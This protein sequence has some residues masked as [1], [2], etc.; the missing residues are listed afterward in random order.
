MNTNDANRD[1]DLP[2]TRPYTVMNL[3]VEGMTCASCVA[4]V[5][6]TLKKMEGVENAAVNLA[7]EKATVRFD[8]SRVSLHQLQDA[9]ADAGYTLRIPTGSEGAPS[10][11]EDP[12]AKTRRD[13]LHELLWSVALTIPVMALS[14]LTMTAW[15]ASVSPISLEDTN[16]ILLLLTTPVLFGPGRRFFRGFMAAARH[17]TADMNTLVAVGTGAAYLYSLT[18]TLFPHLLNLPASAHVYFDTAATI[19]TLILFGKYLEASAKRRASS[20]IRQLAALQPKAAHVLREDVITDIPVEQVV[21]GD[22]LVVRPGESIPVDGVILSGSTTVNESLMTGESMPVEKKSGDA[23]IGGSINNTGSVTF[24][25]TAVG[26]DTVLARI[27]RLV[28]DAQGAKAPVQALADRI[29]AIFVPA[30]VSVALAAF[31]VWFF[32]LNVTF[33]A[34]MLNFIAV[35]IIA[36]PCALGLATPTAIMVGSG[37]AAKRGILIRNIESL[38]RA[39]DIS[40]VVFD[41][42]GTLTEGSPRVVDIHPSPPF[43]R[44]ALLRTVS[45]LEQASEHPLA[46]AIVKEARLGGLQLTQPEDLQATPGGGVSG[47]V[48]GHRVLAGSLEFVEGS[49]VGGMRDNP[50]WRS[51]VEGGHTLIVVAVDGKITGFIEVADRLRASAREAVARLHA[52]GLRVAMITGDNEQT[53]RSIAGEAGIEL[54]VARVPP[55]KK[56]ER[57]KELQKEGRLVAMIGDGINDAPALAQADIGIAMGTGTAIAAEAADITLMREDLN[58]IPEALL[59]SRRTLRVIH[60]NLFWAFIYNMI[61]IPLAA[62]G[63]LNPMIGA[64]AMAFSSVSVVSNSLRLKRFPASRRI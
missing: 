39:R 30:V 23:L 64:L 20:A 59:L 34:A 24:K 19:I 42:T 40:T 49:G 11:D 18:A 46:Q 1:T 44:D 58:G 54:V 17:F 25:A 57:I 53:A 32:V 36:C 14:M 37:T 45:S 41:K 33:T 3:P 43:S 16:K 62:L 29:A 50:E 60:Q 61:G 47:I 55:D 7:T 22:S 12:S 6:K 9:V 48:D 28:E 38:E 2:V 10:P 5:E 63:M 15:Y 51:R 8:A 26:S 56:A 27:I 4:R 31:V 21:P 35:L 13:L 52:L